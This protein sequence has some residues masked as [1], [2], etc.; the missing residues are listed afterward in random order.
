MAAPAGDLAAKISVSLPSPGKEAQQY[1]QQQQQQQLHKGTTGLLRDFTTPVIVPVCGERTFNPHHDQ[2]STKLVARWLPAV[3]LNTFGK[4]G[5]V[6]LECVFLGFAIYGCTKVYMVGVGAAVWVPVC[7][8]SS[9]SSSIGHG[10][11]QG[12]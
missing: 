2:L 3:S 9:S 6:I 1:P 11:S 4:I 5:V 7:S 8:G 12:P 10:R